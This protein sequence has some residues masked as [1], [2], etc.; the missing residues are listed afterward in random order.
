MGISVIVF[1]LM[2]VYMDICNVSGFFLVCR[3]G[4]PTKVKFAKVSLYRNFIDCF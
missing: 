4:T 3:E 1:S 2:H